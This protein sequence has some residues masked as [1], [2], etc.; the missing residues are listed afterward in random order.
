MVSMPLSSGR[1]PQ[2]AGIPKKLAA[3][4]GVAVDARRRNRSLEGLQANVA[5]LKAYRSNLVIFPRNAKRPRKF[6]VRAFCGPRQRFLLHSACILCS[7]AGLPPQ[8]TH[9]HAR[10]RTHSRAHFHARARTRTHH[11]HL[12]LPPSPPGLQGGGGGGGGTGEG[13]HNAHHQGGGQAGV[14]GHHAGHEGAHRQTFYPTSPAAGG[15]GQ[16]VPGHAWAL[17]TSAHPFSSALTPTRCPQ[18]FKAYTKLRIERMNAR[19]IGVRAKRAKEAEA[20]EK[21]N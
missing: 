16:C 10:T 14:G 4:L 21:E 8:N 1:R 7:R 2:E 20:A 15:A 17:A 12:L 18:D 3:T 6:E 13:H 19:L 9:S 11:P 5:R